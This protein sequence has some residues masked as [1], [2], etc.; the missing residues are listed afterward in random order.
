MDKILNI[1]VSFLFISC[2]DKDPVLNGNEELVKH[3]QSFKTNSSLFGKN[4]NYPD[5]RI[6]F[7]KTR[8]KEKPNR[9]GYCKI[10]FPLSEIVI[11]KETYDSLS[12]ADKEAIVYHELGHCVLGKGHTDDCLIEQNGTCVKPKSI[13]NSIFRKNIYKPSKEYYMKELFGVTK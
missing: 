9:V 6:Y 12:E 10:S 8:T 7:G 5:M 2:G 1:I 3:V 4:F 13:M 11:E